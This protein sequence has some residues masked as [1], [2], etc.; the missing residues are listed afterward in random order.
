MKRR[1]LF[2]WE[3]QAWLPVVFRNFITD[4][5]RYFLTRKVRGPVNRAIA[6]HLKSVLIKTGGKQIIDLCA[7]A[8]GPLLEVQRILSE[9][10]DEP[11]EVLLTDLY[12]NVEAFRRREVEGGGAIKAR[13]DSISAFDV[14][15]GLSGLRTLFT[16]LHHFEP[17]GARQLLADAAHKRQPIAVFE[18]LERTPRMFILTG[19]F[20]L[21]QS[22]ALTPVVG[23]LTL[24]RFLLTYVIPIAPAIFLWDGLV[25]VLR[26][27]S[28]EELREMADSVGAEDYDWEVG[29]IYVSGPCGVLLP[30]IFLIGC[31][32]IA[33]PLGVDAVSPDEVGCAA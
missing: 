2:E 6:G 10:M 27:Y 12:P 22:F 21:W 13:Y 1:H 29:R 31:P 7:G 28:P 15:L 11:V 25:S 30:T 14:P 19:L 5:L 23:R 9:D 3:D 17:E 16:A 24:Q 33:A 8:G 20:S 4:H 18:L 26:T 32:Q